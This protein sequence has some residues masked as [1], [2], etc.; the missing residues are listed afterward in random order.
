M[1]SIKTFDFARHEGR[2][3]G[4]KPVILGFI[5]AIILVALAFLFA[6]TIMGLFRDPVET[7]TS[8]DFEG[9]ISS[10]S[11]YVKSTADQLVDTFYY[12]ESGGKHTANFYVFYCQPGYVIV[13]ASADYYDKIY[14]N[15]EVVGKLRTPTV[16]E[17]QVIDRI[18]GEIVQSNQVDEATARE[19]FSPYVIDMTYSR[20]G[21]QAIVCACALIL[22]LAVVLIIMGVMQ[23]VAPTETG[24]YRRIENYTGQNPDEV[25]TIISEEISK[26][27]SLLRKKLQ[28]LPSFSLHRTLLGYTVRKT[29]DII[30]VY[31]TTGKKDTDETPDNKPCFVVLNFAGGFT[32]LIKCKNTEDADG[33][34]DWLYANVPFAIFGFSPELKELFDSDYD[35]FLA[36][37]AAEK[38]EKEALIMK[39]EEAAQRDALSDDGI[40]DSMMEASEQADQPEPEELPEPEEPSAEE[41]ISQK[42]EISEQQ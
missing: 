1:E 34:I 13:R 5:V 19:I 12:N 39:D 2:R 29:E 10:K 25:N 17:S 32:E 37:W 40:N 15:R 3:I 9:L 31:K 42:D 28:I 4:W 22:L 11:T 20:L 30:W 33:V 6:P 26:G 35:C 24:N 16:N 7:S 21:D 8:A 41:D 38:A 36:K 23:I 18:V 27:Q 14:Y